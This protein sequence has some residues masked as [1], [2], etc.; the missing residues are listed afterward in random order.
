[1]R[2]EEVALLQKG[3]KRAKGIPAS[4]RIAKG[5]TKVSRNVTKWDSSSSLLRYPAMLF[6]CGFILAASIPAIALEGSENAYRKKTDFFS[7]GVL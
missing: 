7:L 3:K 6:G 5:I 1:M 2:D 4:L